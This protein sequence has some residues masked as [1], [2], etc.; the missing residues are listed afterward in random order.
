M[1]D[2]QVSKSELAFLLYVAQFQDSY[3]T[4]HSV[5]Y[6]D[7]CSAINI[8]IQKFYD[9]LRSLA[10]KRLI[11]YQKDNPADFKVHLVGNNFENL[12]FSKGYINVAEKDF[13]NSN[14]ISLKV[15]SQLLYLYSQRF[16]EGKHMLLQ[17]FYDEFSKLFHVTRKTIQLYVQELKEQKYLFI[18]KKR[19]RAYHYEMVMKRSS[20]LNKKGIIPR[21][22]EG[23]LENIK[24]LLLVNFKNYINPSDASDQKALVD[25]TRLFETKRAERQR[26][27]PS[28]IVNSVKES[29][30]LQK[31]ERKKE[32]RLNAALVNKCFTRRYNSSYGY[33]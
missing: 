20:C 6:K 4:V 11:I 15:G 18:S 8:S 19:N 30:R 33:T 23:Y 24:K 26:D 25:I 2:K 29:F 12:D 3:G 14:F 16:V 27:F 22:K 32:I 17:N 21:E 7:V 10:Q 9:I 28:L 1:I 5:Y 31:D 13:C